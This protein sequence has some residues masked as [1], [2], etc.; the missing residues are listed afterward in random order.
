MTTESRDRILADA[1]RSDVIR[2][3]GDV[4]PTVLVDGLV[5]GTWR[6]EDGRV[7]VAPFA[8]LPRRV[9]RELDDEAAALAAFHG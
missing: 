7:A 6:V 4:R 8:P 5:A 1:H 9:R 3:N 2:R